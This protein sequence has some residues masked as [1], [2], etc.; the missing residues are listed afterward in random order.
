MNDLLSAL[1]QVGRL[2]RL[3]RAGW[4]RKGL[5]GTESVADHSFRTAVLALALAGELGVD[6][7]RLLAL[8]VVHDLPES[9][10][11]VGDITPSCGISREEKRA[12]ERA[13]MDRLCTGM[14]GGD[15]L[16]SLWVEYDEGQ[17][18][19]ARAA[20]ELDALEMALQAR[21]YQASHGF[22]PSE[23]VASARVK[24]HHPALLEI[25]D[26]LVR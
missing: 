14:P 19:E 5:S 25:L 20:H 11:D 24:I 7:G 13:A 2:K 10:P 9:D 4:V 23:F 21:E 3:R 1:A 15:V 6:P 22:D 8:A 18:P 26:G 17:T 12:K 16:L